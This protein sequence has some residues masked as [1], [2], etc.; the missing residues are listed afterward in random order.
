[1]EEGEL[2]GICREA[3][4]R[5]HKVL[6]SLRDR[7]RAEVHDEHVTDISTE[8]DMAVSGDLIGFFRERGIPAVLFSEESGRIELA[9]KPEYAIAL[10]ELDG[11]DNYH[12]GR[13]VLPCCTVVCIF[14]S[15]EP[16]FGDALAAGIMEH[17]SGMVW[18]A[19]RGGGC[20]LDNRRVRTSG[21]KVLDRRTLVIIDHYVCGEGVSG[22]LALYPRSWVKDFGSTALHLAGVGSGMFD[23]YLAPPSHKAYELGAGYLLVKEAGGFLSD[24]NGK[25][26][27]R[28]EYDFFANY[29]LLAASSRELGQVLL[30]RIRKP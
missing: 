26:L 29:S 20:F 8:G 15:P 14:D 16:R 22:L 2:A 1:M 23:A 11:T 10:D 4:D 17:N 24:W 9:K 3:L 30:S 5:A 18:H 28:R 13:G 19:I 21:R 12:R 27:G 7:G 6:E 25:P